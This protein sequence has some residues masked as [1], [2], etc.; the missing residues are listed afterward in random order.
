LIYDAEH[1][2]QK[3]YYDFNIR[4]HPQFVEKLRYIHRNPVREDY[5]NSPQTGS[6]IALFIMLLAKKD[7]FKLNLI[8]LQIFAKEQR[9]D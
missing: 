5:A 1:F 2:W 4:N 6:G 7:G 9:E 8:G 3:R